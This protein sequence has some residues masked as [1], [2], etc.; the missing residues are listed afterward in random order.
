V[1]PLD[2]CVQH[3]LALAT[4]TPDMGHRSEYPF[5]RIKIHAL[6]TVETTAQ[7][8]FDNAGEG[9]TSLMLAI[10]PEAV[11]MTASSSQRLDVE[12]AARANAQKNSRGREMILAHVQKVLGLPVRAA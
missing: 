11:D 1:L 7:Y 12:S 6:I 4:D 8:P 5:K 2:I 9:N 10:R 3:D